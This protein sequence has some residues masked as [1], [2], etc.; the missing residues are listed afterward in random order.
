V[1][2]KERMME[3][4]LCVNLNEEDG[5]VKIE[6]ESNRIQEY[7]FDEVMGWTTT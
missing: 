4:V 1:L 6:D 7:N 2:I 5:Q 3:E